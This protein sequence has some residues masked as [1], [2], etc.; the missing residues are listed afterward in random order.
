MTTVRQVLAEKGSR[1][2]I[3][4][5]DATVFEA[6]KTMADENI[7]SLVVMDGGKMIGILTERTYARNVALRGTST[8]TSVSEIMERDVI[9]VDPERS[10]AECM[11]M[12][13][14]ARVRHLPVLEGGKLVGL[15]SIGDVVRRTIED[16]QF[17]L[18]EMKRYVAT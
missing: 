6:L 17:D 16:Q 14:L 15:I 11:G 8:S 2:W 18:E 4:G 1:V 12:M 13:T 5:P 10:I 9:S 7:G 3:I